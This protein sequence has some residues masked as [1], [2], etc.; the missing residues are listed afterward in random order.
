MAPIPYRPDID[1]LRAIAVLLVIG[2]HAF[3]DLFP[4]GFVGVDIFFV[5][6][7]FLITSIL[8][9]DSQ[10]SGIQILRF[11]AK[12]ILRIFPA[13]ILVLGSC[14]VFGWYTLLGDEYMQLG[15]HI[16]SG[17]LFVS[18][19]TLWFE[20][21][22]FDNASVTKPLLHLWSLGI[23][24]Q[25]YIVWPFALAMCVRRNLPTTK[26][27]GAVILVSLAYSCVLVFQ[28]PTAGFY[29]PLSR[30]WELLAGAM[31]A[32]FQHTKSR[33][34]F[35]LSR[36]FLAWIGFAL[37]AVSVVVLRASDRFPGALAV[38][39][40]LGTTLLIAAN[41]A[42][43]LN[44]RILS[45]SWMAGLGKISYPLYLWHWPL[46]SFATIILSGTPAWYVRL[47][48]VLAS[49]VL[50]LLTYQLLE[51]PVRTLPRKLSIGL[52]LGCMVVLALLGRNI[53]DREGLADI[54]LKS[55]V[56][57]GPDAQHDFV[58]WEK[59]GLIT[60]ASCEIPFQFPGRSYCVKK[61]PA[62][63]PTAVVLGDSHAFHAYW[64]LAEVLDETGDNLIGIGRGACVPF[65]DYAQG[66]DSDQCQPHINHMIAYAADNPEI[67]K[68]FLI[69]RGRYLPNSASPASVRQ[70]HDG[71]ERTLVR[72]LDA[73][74]L[75]YYF[76]PV[77]E[78]GFEPRFC[79]GNLP[80]GRRAPQSCELSRS[81]DAFHSVL[82]RKEAMAVLTQHPGVHVIDPNDF[83]CSGDSCP[84]VRAGHSMF[85]DE[86]HL[87]YPGSLYL[88]HALQSAI[89]D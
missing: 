23:E 19:L 78:T 70:F 10:G 13:L 76:L 8:L 24:E 45:N 73:G 38:P 22:Y 44:A 33:F 64:G 14:I 63:A 62:L 48:L 72:L 41:P 74:K 50:A 51:K 58:D 43:S 11:Y 46:L 28:N 37:V 53:L 17:A 36:P 77:V 49:F 59:S 20:S 83:L 67:K 79:L 30:A 16:F 35:M 84:V 56:A 18:N 81:A 71:L 31:L 15:K 57:L 68:V 42:G 39:A 5:I 65:L 61:H 40:V 12:R 9:L 87:S 34:V 2:F 66:D 6:S 32:N 52:L 29:S 27:L 69:F 47:A 3:P 25:F 55:M 88:A 86:N 26:W 89:N 54:R 82:L 21:N 4:G 1:G 7:G 85:K 60:E 80:F 75:V